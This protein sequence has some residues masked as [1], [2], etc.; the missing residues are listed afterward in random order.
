[1]KK[2]YL[3]SLVSTITIGFS[4]ISAPSSYAV[5][6]SESGS[7]SQSNDYPNAAQNI[8]N[9][10]ERVA[11][12]ISQIVSPQPA[13]SNAAQKAHAAIPAVVCRISIAYV[14]SYTPVVNWTYQNNKLIPLTTALV[15]ST[16][17]ESRICS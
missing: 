15:V 17:I 7:S 16:P 13:D 8:G 4:L 2:G 3:L 1:M 9:A 11:S 5:L 14:L 6:A 10:I 12:T